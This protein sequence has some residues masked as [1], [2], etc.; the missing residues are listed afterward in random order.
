MRSSPGVVV[1]T[2]FQNYSFSLKLPWIA[3][4]Y[5]APPH[6]IW[7]VMLQIFF[8]GSDP[9]S[10]IWKLS[11]N[12]MK[13]VCLVSFFDQLKLTLSE[14]RLIQYALLVDTVDCMQMHQTFS[15]FPCICPTFHARHLHIANKT[16]LPNRDNKGIA[17]HFSSHNGTD[18]P[19]STSS[20]SL[21]TF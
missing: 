17:A 3:R 20:K 13:F 16:M 4:P 19:L 12:L 14:V 9:L 21:Q 10:P 11:E 15:S 8:I 18:I 2:W 1:L 5:H 6:W 7:E